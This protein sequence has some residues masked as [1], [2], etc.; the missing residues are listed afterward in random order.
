MNLTC[1]HNLPNKNR[2]S[3]FLEIFLLSLK[4]RTESFVKLK[5]EVQAFLPKTIEDWFECAVRISEELS[6][7]NR[8]SEAVTQYVSL[9]KEEI[10]SQ[11]SSISFLVE[12]DLVPYVYF[13]NKFTHDA[14]QRYNLLK[15]RSLLEKCLIK[16]ANLTFCYLYYNDPDFGSDQ[17]RK[18]LFLMAK[19]RNRQVYD[20][21]CAQKFFDENV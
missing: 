6:R 17:H 21:L 12:N 3:N 15:S 18:E 7:Q 14:N 5:Y 4:S 2:G 20:F 13:L 10:D 19:D 1:L 9:V 11:Y 16:K 8:S